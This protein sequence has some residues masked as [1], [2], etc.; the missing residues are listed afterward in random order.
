MPHPITAER[1][2]KNTERSEGDCMEWQGAIGSHGY[3]TARYP[4]GK[5]DAAHRVAWFL[6]RGEKAPTGKFVCHS[7]DNRRCV[8]PKHLWLG[9]PSENT[10]DAIA[11]GR[12]K[13]P[14]VKLTESEVRRIRKL[15]TKGITQAELSRMFGV[16]RGT[17]W[18]IVHRKTW[19]E[20][21]E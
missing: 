2:W 17:V 3:G 11:K 19:T 1:F 10:K 4:G 8:N 13:L 9:T 21:E 18:N 20:L 5:V 12:F 16:E 7:C 15:Y 14:N 6:S